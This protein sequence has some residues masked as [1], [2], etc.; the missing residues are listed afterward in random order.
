VISVKLYEKLTANTAVPGANPFTDTSNQD[1]LKAYELGIVRG[2][3]ANRFAPNNSITRQEMCVMIFRALQAAGESTIIQ[4]G[5]SFTFIDAD[6]IA[7]WALNE[8]RFCNQ[9]NIMKGTSQSTISP[10]RNTPREQAIVMI[11]RAYEAFK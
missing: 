9:R 5:I 4:P 8:V 1:I 2:V 6:S 10:L 3:S 11:K 7:P